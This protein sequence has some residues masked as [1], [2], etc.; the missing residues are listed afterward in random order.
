M[1]KQNNQMIKELQN[2]TQPL[3]KHLIYRSDARRNEVP[4]YGFE[5]SD[6]SE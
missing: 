2:K 4:V 1:Y 3:P 5:T 6:H